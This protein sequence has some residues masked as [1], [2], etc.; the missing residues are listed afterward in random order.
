VGKP[1]LSREQW[2]ALDIQYGV[3]P[4]DNDVDLASGE[5]YILVSLLNRFGYRPRSRRDALELAEEL[6]SNGHK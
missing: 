4:A 5:H 3:T 6:L 2:V 1:K